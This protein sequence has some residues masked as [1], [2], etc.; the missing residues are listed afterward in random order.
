SNAWTF[1]NDTNFVLSGGVNGLSFDTTTFSVDATNHRIGIGTAAP[2]TKLEVVGTISG[3]L[4]TIS[5]P[6]STSYLLGNL[7]IGSSAASTEKLE[8]I[9]T[10]SGRVLYA[11]DSL[12]SSGSLVFEG[13]A[14]GAS[15]TVSNGLKGS[16]L[17]DCDTPGTS[18][19]LWDVTTSRFSCGS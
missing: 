17:T 6:T 8:V 18:K 4:L 9:G 3:A 2:K 5:D 1:A 16:G 13:A 15:L 12:R 7:S 10:A 19:L 11:S 14:S